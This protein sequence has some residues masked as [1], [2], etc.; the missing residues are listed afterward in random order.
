[1]ADLNLKIQQMGKLV[2]S[3]EDGEIKDGLNHLLTDMH[4]LQKSEYQS[5]MAWE[6]G[7]MALVGTDGL[8]GVKRI[9][10]QMLSTFDSFLYMAP[11]SMPQ[12]VPQ[13][14]Q[15]ILDYIQAEKNAARMPFKTENH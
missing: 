12:M 1:M 11:E 6:T 10:S 2:D 13:K 8:G 5:E 3:L 15:Q 14:S 4:Q 7:M 9:V